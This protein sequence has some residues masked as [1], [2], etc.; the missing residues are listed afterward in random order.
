M[1]SYPIP[2]TKRDFLYFLPKFPKEI[3]ANMI[4]YATFVLYYSTNTVGRET[5]NKLNNNPTDA[6]ACQ[7][8]H[9]TK[10]KASTCK[11]KTN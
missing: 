9:N 8:T 2:P 7:S 4:L 3:F 11:G 5:I 1:V 10:A 6:V